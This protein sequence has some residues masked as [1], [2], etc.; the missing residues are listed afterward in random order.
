MFR[1][2]SFFFVVFLLLLFVIVISC[3]YF[4]LFIFRFTYF[5]GLF[6]VRVLKLLLPPFIRGVT[7]FYKIVVDSSV[8]IRSY[9]KILPNKSLFVCFF[10]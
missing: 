5:F 6:P 2:I 7:Y 4:F 10:I 9:N 8:V 3:C 1:F